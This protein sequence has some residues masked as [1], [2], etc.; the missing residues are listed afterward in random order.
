MADPLAIADAT[1]ALLLPQD[2]V[3]KRVIVSAGPTREALDP[4][5]FISNRS[6][7]KM[8][9]ALAH[10][11]KQRGAEVTLVHGP[12]ALTPKTNAIAVNS[13]QE[14]LDALKRLLPADVLIMAAAV[15]DYAPATVS[16]S[17]LKKTTLGATPSI[18]LQQTPD[19]VA[20]LPKGQTL[21]VGFAAETNDVDQNANKKLTQK[22]LDLIVANDISQPG[23]G[24][25]ADDT[26]CASSDKNGLVKDSGRAS[27][28][29]HR[30]HHPRH[31]RQHQALKLVRR[32]TVAGARS[33]ALD[34]HRGR[35][36]PTP[37]APGWW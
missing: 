12:V 14:M 30:A 18:A 5:R 16:A 37:L 29:P 3:G 25:D 22:G 4:V 21:F 36:H 26:M 27:K 28:D 20:S 7:G 13:A 8:G 23:I 15:A 24:M 34:Q 9:F 32:L 11:A 1:E 2:F 35:A 10:A 6:S 17:K 19:V 33:P 31:R